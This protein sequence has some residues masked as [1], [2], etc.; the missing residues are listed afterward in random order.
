MSQYSVKDLL[1]LMERLRDP[2]TGCEWD[3]KQTAQ[4]ITPLTIEEVY[5]VVDA[6]DHQDWP[7]LCGELGDLLFHV[8]FYSQLA[9]EEQYFDFSEVVDTAVNK[10]VRRH[11]HVFPKGLYSSHE[12]NK[13]DAASVARQWEAIKKAERNQMGQP[14]LLENI[15][16]ALPAMTRAAKLQKRASSVGL[17]WSSIDGV[18][19][20]VR[21]ELDELESV[22][23][24]RVAASDELG[25]VLFSLVNLSRHLKLD[26]ESALRGANRKFSQR[27]MHIDKSCQQNW[28]SKSADDLADLWRE[29]K[30]AE[31]EV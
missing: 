11:P 9:C 15:P 10:L 13:P 17:D 1:Y 29:A 24:D 8:I 19:A 23:D 27:V 26:P 7:S 3:L 30:D 2:E 21:G 6:I 18:I 14:G 31:K 12:G 20:C 16:S 25:D 28:S 4:S 5:E 22:L